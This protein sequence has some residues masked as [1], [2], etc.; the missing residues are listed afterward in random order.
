MGGFQKDRLDGLVLYA[1]QLGWLLT[2]PEFEHKGSGPRPD[3]VTRAK[4]M[5]GN[6]EFPILPPLTH[7]YLVDWWMAVGPTMAG[8]SEAPV[9]WQEIAAWS[10]QTTLQLAPWEA[11]AIRAMSQAFAS[12][13]YDA[14]KPDCPAPYTEAAQEAVNTDARV[15]NQFKALMT[16]LSKQ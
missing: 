6:G 13:R 3:P 7:P 1:R 16:A 10:A 4:A 12:Q 14:R 5:E 15:A 8:A 11:E 2:A 9:S